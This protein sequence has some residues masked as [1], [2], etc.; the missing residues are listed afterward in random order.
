MPAPSESDLSSTRTLVGLS[1]EDFES[2]VDHLRGLRA[3][4]AGPR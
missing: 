3:D 4:H 2:F 1:D